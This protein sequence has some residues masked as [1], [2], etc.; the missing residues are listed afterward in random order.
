VKPVRILDP[1][2]HGAQALLASFGPDPSFDG[3]SGVRLG[4]LRSPS[5]Y[6]TLLVGNGPGVGVKVEG[7]NG[8]GRSVMLPPH[9][10]KHAYGI[11]IG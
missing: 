2:G 5:G 3:G 8:R 10:D 4:S 11:F 9:Q 7:F 1:N 6:D